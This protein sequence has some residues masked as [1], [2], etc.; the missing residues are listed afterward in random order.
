MRIPQQWRES[1]GLSVASGLQRRT[2]PPTETTT[3]QQRTGPAGEQR[4]R[5]GFVRAI[6]VDATALAAPRPVKVNVGLPAEMTTPP[7]SF[8]LVA[9]DSTLEAAAPVESSV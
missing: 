9:L 5:A 2:C 4:P 7:I 1:P 8:A 3:F 6:P